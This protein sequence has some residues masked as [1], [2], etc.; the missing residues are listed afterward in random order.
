MIKISFIIPIFNAEAFLEA[1]IESVTCQLE[2]NELILIDDGSTD[3]SGAICDR[4]AS[5]YAQ[6]SVIHTENGGVSRARNLGVERAQGEYIVFL[7]ADDYINR[8]FS[9]R[10]S[11]MNSNADII[12]YPMRKQYGQDNFIPMGFGL[13][14]KALFGKTTEEVLSYISKCPKFPASPC[15]RLIR[16]DFLRS[17][18]ITFSHNKITEDYDWTYS[19]LRY[20]QSYDFFEGGMYTYRQV[21]NSRSAIG[22]TKSV[23]DQLSILCDWIERDVEESYRVWLNCF[24]A[25]EYAMI[26]PFYGAL[27]REQ[28]ARFRPEM[29][30]ASF[31]LRF[32]KT[33][34]LKLIRLAVALLGVDWAAKVLNFYVTYRDKGYENL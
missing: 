32:G 26:F 24:L 4:Y 13:N 19:L 21:G 15:G 25:Y 11:E 17:Y 9:D 2:G 20:A 1:C 10:F 30:R 28:R 16:L 33:K 29:M 18:G 3:S 22:S 14:R 12:F 23:E 27:T 6:V 34:K 5:Q 7:D 31:L 8:D